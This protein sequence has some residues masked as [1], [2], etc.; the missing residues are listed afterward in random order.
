[1]NLTLGVAA[2]VDAGKTTL[3]EQLLR[4]AGVIRAC[5]RVDHGDAFM[6]DDPMERA[7]GITIFTE[8]A[9]LSW[10]VSGGEPLFV[11][12]MDTPGHVDFSGEMERALSV[13]DAALLVVSC[14]EG[15]QSHTVTLFRLLQKR[16]IPTI[17]FLNK[18]D[19]EGAD[20]ARVTAQMRRLLS[21]DCV[22][23]A[24]DVREALAERDELLLE[25]HLEE[26]ASRADYL[27]GARRAFAACALYP[28]LA[29]SALGDI[30]VDA[31]AEAVGALCRTDYA[32]REG[33]PFSAKAYRVRRVGGVRYTY[34]KVTSGVLRARNEVRTISGVCKVAAILAPQ[35]GRL[36]PM[37]E[38]HAGQTAALAGLSA[39]P[40]ERI[41]DGF[42]LEA[43][44][45]VP[46]MSVQVEP[47][48]PLTQSA[49]L[50]HLR[51]MEEEDPLLSVRPEA[52]GVSV[53]VM[54]AV[55][56][57]VLQGILAA[58]FGDVVRMCP[59]HVLYKETIAAPVV[60]IGH[61]EP[62]RHYAEVWLKIE[63]GAPGSGISF[64]ADCPPNSL[65]ENWQ[66]LIR[67]HVFE[68][69]H[70]GVLTGSPLCDVRIRL[71]AGRAHLKHTEGGDFREATCRAIRNAL[72]QAE[73][74]LLEPVVRFELAMPNEA[75]ARVTG[76]LLRIGAQLDASET[77]G[78]ETTLTGRCTAA[79][80]WD[81]PTRFA[82]STHG[83]GRI[84]SRFD[85]YEPC[86]NQDDIVRQSGYDPLADTLN[87]PGSVF[88][89]HGAGF[90]VAW[91]H[92]R[93]WAHCEVE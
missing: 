76:E 36:L 18:T 34:V 70:P 60:G 8:Q 58:R 20:A 19:R 24:G 39:R 26:T 53:G 17:I 81:Y 42:G 28:V 69:A 78:G 45:T 61:Y 13:L 89:S 7:R 87:P 23:M 50:A 63:P 67:T 57:E 40:G 90:Y 21:G 3:C 16:K 35:G 43:P 73:N 93:E 30:G 72:M 91:D 25:Q 68:R 4:R 83:H 86:K 31:L 47:T 27:S 88:C 44:E 59:P 84:A 62:L 49:L 71:I 33:E 66:R 75:L 22:L 77:D 29:G 92:V 1:M 85:R 54:G 55:Q 14:A 5:G 52:D 41:G 2:H 11:T 51:E 79:M 74:V 65:D 32:R 15:V 46:L 37:G 12:L 64:A 38:A 82:A 6:D 10:P 48:A 56:V 9:T 80:F